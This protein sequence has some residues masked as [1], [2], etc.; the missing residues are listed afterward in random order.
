[1]VL[2]IITAFNFTNES[3]LKMQFNFLICSVK[4]SIL[5]KDHEFIIYALLLNKI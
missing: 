1:M 4:L 2:K 3:G 5:E